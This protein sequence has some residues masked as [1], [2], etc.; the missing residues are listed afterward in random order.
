[1][2]T[3]LPS[4]ADSHLCSSKDPVRRP[5]E[6]EQS[7][8]LANPDGAMTKPLPHIYTSDYPTPIASSAASSPIPSPDL[9]PTTSQNFPP[10]PTGSISFDEPNDQ[11]DELSSPTYDSVYLQ[12]EP[13]SPPDL[14]VEATAN[15]YP[16]AQRIPAVDDSSVEEEPSR[17][18]DYFTHEWKEEDIW[19]S[20]RYVVARRGTYEHSVRLENASWRTWTKLRNNLRTISPEALNWLKDCDVTWLYGPLKTFHTLEEGPNISPPPSFSESPSRKSILKKR[21]ASETMLQRS[22]SQRTLLRHAG[23]I[24]KAQEAEHSRSRSGFASH[25]QDFL[26][27]ADKACAPGLQ[28]PRARPSVNTSSSNAASSAEKR[29]IHFNKEVLQCIAVEAKDEEEECLEF[30]GDASWDDSIIVK[31][32]SPN[33]GTTAPGSL[34]GDTNKTIAPLPS[35]TL[36]YRSDTPEPKEPSKLSRWSWAK[37]FSRPILYSPSHA[38]QPRQSS[39]T[40]APGPEEFA[41]DHDW[42]SSQDTVESNRSWFVDSAEED[43]A[44][45]HFYLASLGFPPPDDG[46]P[47]NSVLLMDRMVDTVNTAKD[48]AHVIWN[49]GWPG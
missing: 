4:P 35:T 21:S 5:I 30:G 26:H 16:S 13:N 42:S 20:W 48:I 38:G 23:A 19:T 7:Y 18:V 49:V 2:T 46:Q 12:E 28:T 15:L 27:M 14:L 33:A 3:V 9:A 6:I 34:N 17:H 41:S 11:D 43:E 47:S 37:Y 45:Q 36:K 40:A 44:A 29:H 32:A 24:L 22:L 10:T 39:G 1:M 8:F 25:V 31:P